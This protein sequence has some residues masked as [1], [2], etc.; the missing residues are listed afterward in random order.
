VKLGT[1]TPSGADV[2]S[3]DP[4]E[5]CTVIDPLLEEHLLHWGIDMKK[6]EKTEKTINEMEL[7]LNLKF[8][9]NKITEASSELTPVYGP[10]YIGLKNLGN[11][12][13]MNA[14]VQASPP[15]DM[16]SGHR[17]V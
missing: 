11:S 12:C 15:L 13:Y 10:G 8:E 1:I 7:D 17:V 5:D 16:E 14:V 4:E 3:Y 2:Y 9:F 6:M